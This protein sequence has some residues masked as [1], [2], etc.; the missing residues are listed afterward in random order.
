VVGM[1]HGVVRTVPLLSVCTELPEMAWRGGFGFGF[2][3]KGL[4]VRCQSNMAHTAEYEG[5]FGH[6]EPDFPS[7]YR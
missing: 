2:K 5:I 1:C 3:V 7:P 4:V 6:T